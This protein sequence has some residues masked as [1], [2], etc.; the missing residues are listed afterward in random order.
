MNKYT[1]PLWGLLWLSPAALALQILPAVDYATIDATIA[2][3]DLTRIVV[4]D[5]RIDRIQGLASHFQQQ[6]AEGQPI[7]DRDHGILLIQ[8]SDQDATEPFTVHISTEQQHHYTLHLTPTAQAAETVLLQPQGSII[9]QAQ[10]LPYVSQLTTLMTAMLRQ[11]PLAGYVDKTISKADS[12]IFDKKSRLQLLA[13]YQ[14]EK[15]RGEIYRLHNRL[16]KT[17]ILTETSFIRPGVL[18]LSL[19]APTLKAHRETL[20]YQVVQHE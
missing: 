20:L 13:V 5:D 6:L 8:P 10:A 1:L 9:Q 17:V 16:N 4:Q 7:I 2:Q 11:Q 14:G 19:A 3:D 18:A 12:I 15:I